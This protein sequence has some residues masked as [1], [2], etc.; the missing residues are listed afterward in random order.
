MW[1]AT[2]EV[3]DESIVVVDMAAEGCWNGGIE[4]EVVPSCNLVDDEAVVRVEEL[5]FFDIPLRIEDEVVDFS[6][7]FG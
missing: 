6:G 3:I 7:R 5:A 4:G 2:V 1:N